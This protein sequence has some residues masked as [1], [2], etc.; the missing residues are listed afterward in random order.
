MSAQKNLLYGLLTK[1]K[2]ERAIDDRCCAYADNVFVA[3]S[4][5]KLVW[6]MADASV[7]D[8]VRS[9]AY[10]WR[11]R[12]SITHTHVFRTY[13]NRP[14]C[15]FSTKEY[16]VFV[17]ILLSCMIINYLESLLCFFRL[18]FRTLNR[19]SHCNTN[20]SIIGAMLFRA[21]QFGLPTAYTDEE[22]E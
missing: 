19:S 10:I 2:E 4:H 17:A 13:P 21:H 6:F 8:T 7:V 20:L 18:N 12:T 22:K 11:S 9:Y 1:N 5:S 15:T 3:E 16:L 14:T